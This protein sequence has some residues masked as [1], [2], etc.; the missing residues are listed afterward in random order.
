MIARG[1]MKV[2]KSV[3]AIPWSCDDPVFWFDMVVVIFGAGCRIFFFIDV[4]FILVQDRDAI[5]VGEL[6][7]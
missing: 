4:Y 2:P 6:S 5:I 3:R 7:N 1:N